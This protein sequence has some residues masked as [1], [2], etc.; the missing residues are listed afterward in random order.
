[1][2]QMNPSVAESKLAL[3]IKK[4][5]SSDKNGEAKFET[6]GPATAHSRFILLIPLPETI[7]CFG[8]QA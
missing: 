5:A 2:H 4:R 1:M 8:F 6:S 3:T 7:N